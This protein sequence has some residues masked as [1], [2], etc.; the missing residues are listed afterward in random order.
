M[1]INSFI[2]ISR[3]LMAFPDKKVHVVKKVVKEKLDQ[4]ENVDVKEIEERKEIKEFRYVEKQ[5]SLNCQTVKFIA[6]KFTGIGC[7]MSVGF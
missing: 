1:L 6:L 4:L 7:T 2:P 3:E 5:Y